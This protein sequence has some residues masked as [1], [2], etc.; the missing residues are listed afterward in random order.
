MKRFIPSLSLPGLALAA[1]LGGCGPSGEHM[2]VL[3]G[4]E[5]K[6]L[7]PL[8]QDIEQCAGARLDFKFIGTL[9]GAEELAGGGAYD[10]AWFSHGKYLSLLDQTRNRIVTQDKIML[11]PVVMG[12]KQSKARAWGW[13]K[14]TT[15]TWRDVADKAASGELRYAMTNPASSNSGFT[16]LVGVAAALSGSQQTFDAGKLDRDAL[17]AF[18]KGQALVAGSSGWLA[19]AYVREQDRL[20]GI[21]NYESVLLQLNSGGQLHEPLVLIYP[22]EGIITADYP[23]M[24][25]NKDK[26]EPFDTLV[27]C[28]KSP[29]TQSALMVESQRRPAIPQVR[30]DERF[31]KN[32]LVELPFPR[33]V[34]EIDELLFTYLDDVRKPS[35]TV[36]VL[37]TSGSMRGRRIDQLRHA[38]SSLT[39]L[40]TSL[41]GQFARFRARETVVLLPFS[42]SVGEAVTFTVDNTDA[43]GESMSALRANI[44]TLEAA[45]GTA[46]YDALTRA[47]AI[48]AEAMKKDP[49]RFFSIVLLTD[50]DNTAGIS[51]NDFSGELAGLPADVAKVKTFPIIFGDSNEYEMQRLG[52]MTGGRT[53]DGQRHALNLVFKKIRGYQ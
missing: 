1:L 35:H 43:Q 18:F 46:I 26:R 29:Q 11:S 37:D 51:L 45:G 34:K 7:K 15:L 49:E 3:A 28:L 9:D 27:Q 36:F 19:D 22:Q 31:P 33:T 44:R 8:Q 52:E 23:I 6:D 39:G 47:Y 30:P 20:E 40:D 14:S 2:S 53:F 25:L 38:M 48:T 42:G 10:I 41:T 24:L 12:V 4:S 13:D 16:A 32:V 50:G 17:K 21:I 5:L